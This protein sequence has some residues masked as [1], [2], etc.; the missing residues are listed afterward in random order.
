MATTRTT[1]QPTHR[2][3]SSTRRAMAAA[4]LVCTALLAT[5]TRPAFGMPTVAQ[6]TKRALHERLRDQFGLLVPPNE[7]LYRGARKADPS[8]AT[9]VK[10]LDWHVRKEGLLTGLRGTFNPHG[11]SVQ[12]DWRAMN[13]EETAKHVVRL[14]VDELGGSVR[15][16]ST[17]RLGGKVVRPEL[18]AAVVDRVAQALIPYYLTQAPNDRLEQGAT[19]K[20]HDTPEAKA[21]RWT[22]ILGNALPAASR[23]FAEAPSKLYQ[24]SAHAELVNEAIE[25]AVRIVDAPAPERTAP[26]ERRLPLRWKRP[27]PPKQQTRHKTPAEGLQAIRLSADEQTL[28]KGLI[29]SFALSKAK[30]IKSLIDRPAEGPEHAIFWVAGLGVVR[31]VGPINPSNNLQL[32][33]DLSEAG[34]PSV[35][36]RKVSILSPATGRQ[37]E[38]S[39]QEKGLGQLKRLD[40]RTGQ[41]TKGHHVR[42]GRKVLQGERSRAATVAVGINKD[43]TRKFE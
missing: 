22:R 14:F 3:V 35:R 30:V 23:A 5:P 29:D 41:L 17:M 38:F 21:L 28:I 10:F 15:R 27:P 12:V 1:F 7:L 6:E 43:L 8:D 13:W 39:L 37:L 19:A 31:G 34:I 33:V 2:P 18:A 26:S 4:I 20:G 36:V 11:G 40:P 32:K 24:P 42:I 16:S 9:T 25:T